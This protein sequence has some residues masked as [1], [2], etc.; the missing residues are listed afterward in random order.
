MK[1]HLLF[2]SAAFHVAN[3]NDILRENEYFFCLLQLR[4]VI[5]ENFDI[6]VCDN[7]VSNIDNLINEDLKTQLKEVQF[8]T[9]DRNIGSQNIGMGELD[10][11]I[12]VSQHVDFSIYDKIVYFTLRKIVTNPWIFE[13]VNK[14]QKNALV[15]NPPF[16]HMTNDYNFKYSQPTP[17][18]YNDMFFALSN[19]LMTQY[20]EYSKIN[21]PTNLQNSIGSEQN[22]YNF[23]QKN[24]IDIEW[25]E[26]L[27]LIRIDY[28]A[29]NE[30]QLI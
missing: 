21:I 30:L 18:L 9:L 2:C 27:G 3:C 15:S 25:L 6:V 24:N 5:P 1:K 26:Y 14:M 8:L 28:H 17:K 13:Q 22:L 20:V 10:E 12:H 16:L 29:Y 4:R 19:E 7:T 11:L 23:I